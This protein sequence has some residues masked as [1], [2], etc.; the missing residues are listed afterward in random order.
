M[1]NMIIATVTALLV[2]AAA[3]AQPAEA[4]CFWNGSVIECHH[5]YPGWWARHHHEGPPPWAYR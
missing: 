2:S 3:L 1:R 4:R 5:H